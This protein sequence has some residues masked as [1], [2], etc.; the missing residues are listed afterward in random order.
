MFNYQNT[1][2]WTKD[3][4][5]FSIAGSDELPYKHQWGF[6]Q[7][8]I[9]LK[10]LL[11][12]KREQILMKRFY[13]NQSIT[14]YSFSDSF[15]NVVY[16]SIFTFQESKEDSIIEIKCL[17]NTSKNKIWDGSDYPSVLLLKSKLDN[18]LKLKGFYKNII[19]LCYLE[20]DNTLIWMDI[21][22]V[23]DSKYKEL[24]FNDKYLKDNLINKRSIDSNRGTENKPAYL[25]DIKYFNVIENINE[26]F[27]IED[28]LIEND[29]QFLLEESNR[30]FLLDIVKSCKLEF[31]NPITI[32]KNT[33]IKSHLDLPDAV[34]LETAVLKKLYNENRK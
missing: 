19:Y 14:D 20:L 6:L 21:K 34:I 15:Q 3:Y 1:K 10:Y 31:R 9:K 30:P 8:F 29:M 26:K 28:L 4:K 11:S 25:L 17:Y 18:L 16:D 22:K 24:I 27:Y 7:S 32:L 12:T 2:D 33:I 5:K 13:E 23:W